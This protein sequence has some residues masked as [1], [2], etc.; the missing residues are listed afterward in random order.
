MPF[1]FL[2]LFFAL[3]L[4]RA[5]KLLIRSSSKCGSGVNDG[6]IDSTVQHDNNTSMCYSVAFSL[7]LFLVR[8]VCVCSV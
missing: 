3:E 2:S 5:Q 7:F 6:G 4:P 1:L 8:C